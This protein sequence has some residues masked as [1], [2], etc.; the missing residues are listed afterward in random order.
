MT[1]EEAKTILLLYRPGTADATDP[2]IAEALALAQQDPDLETWLERQAVLQ[3]IV[4]EKFQQIVPPPGL[5][6]KIIAGMPPTAEKII[7]L[8]RYVA[9]AAAAVIIAFIAVAFTWTRPQHSGTNNLA[10]YNREMVSLAQRAYAMDLATSDPAKIHSYLAQTHAPDFA[11][12]A[13]LRD[14]A[15]TGCAVE[16]WQGAHVSMICFKSGKKRLAAGQS[17]DVWLFVV[18]SSAIPNAKPSAPQLGQIDRVATANWMQ[19]GKLY[20][21]AMLGDENSIKTLL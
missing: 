15:I 7:L 11:V 19:D 12:P 18:D 20:L 1:R 6:E 17:S 9:L 5:K 3:N 10:D 4:R 13:G 14:I 2:Q 16:N 21:L 8:P